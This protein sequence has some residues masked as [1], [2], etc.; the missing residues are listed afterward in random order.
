MILYFMPKVCIWMT[1]ID[2]RQ[3]DDWLDVPEKDVVS[4]GGRSLI[5]YYGSL[6]VGKQLSYW[7]HKCSARNNILVSSLGQEE[8]RVLDKNRKSTSCRQRTGAT[9]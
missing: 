5:S 2:I 6:P 3:L 1:V 7:S 9:A 8:T 4:N